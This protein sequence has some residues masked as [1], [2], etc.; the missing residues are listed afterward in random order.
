MYRIGR[1]Q[2]RA[3]LTGKGHLIALFEKGQEDLAELCCNLL[4]E[5]CNIANVVW[6]SD[7]LPNVQCTVCGKTQEQ[8]LKY[9]C[10]SSACPH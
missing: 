6:R 3:L 9:K 10:I 7:Q 1:K 5:Q 2:K 4:N 8:M